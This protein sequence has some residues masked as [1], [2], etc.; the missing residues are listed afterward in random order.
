MDNITKVKQKLDAMDIP[1]KIVYHK[2]AFSVGDLDDIEF[3][4]K[5][6]IVKN[7]FL[8]DLKGTRHFLI[9]VE[10]AKKADLKKLRQQLGCSALSFASEGRLEKY[11]KL[12]K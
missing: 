1:Y 6:D 9:V 3:E 2:A 8:R 4:N 5:D 11:L 12:S 7:L 10:K